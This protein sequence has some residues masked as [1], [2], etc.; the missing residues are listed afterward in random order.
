M[1]KTTIGALLL[2]LGAWTGPSAAFEPP[3]PPAF[4]TI[5]ANVATLVRERA[6][7]IQAQA[8]PDPQALADLAIA[9]E[10]NNLWA[11]AAQ[12][13]EL[14][15]ALGQD[16]LWRF[17][18]ALCLRESGNLEQSLRVLQSLAKADPRQPWVQERL[19][20]ALFERGDLDGAATAYTQMIA[21]GV[22]NPFGHTGLGQVRLTQGDH[23]AA[24]ASLERAVAIAPT[25]RQARYMLGL[26]YRAQGKREQAAQ[27]LRRGVDG[28]RSYYNDPLSERV[29]EATVNAPARR[30][31]AN[32]LLATRRPGQAAEVLENILAAGEADINDLNNLAVAY[33]QLGRLPDAKR[34][35][36]GVAEEAPEHF[37]T[38]LNLVSLAM[39]ERD[40]PRALRHARRAVEVAPRIARTHQT[41]ARVQA[42]TGDWQGAAASLARAEQLDSRDPQ[43]AAMHGDVLVRLGKDAQAAI[44]Y[45]HALALFPDLLPVQLSLAKLHLR[46]GDQEAARTMYLRAATLAPNN[47]GVKALAEALAAPPT[48]NP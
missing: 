17:H 1:N 39:R 27:A 38:Q 23:A 6:A 9:Y 2:A 14:A 37:G 10:A 24:V 30:N 12:T 34:I 21:T 40:V 43:L 35:L 18:Y 5:D 13:W 45:T 15:L 20:E 48:T 7:V 26:A 42:Q 33:L 41:L 25:Y 46:A 16:A 32:T 8:T 31:L 4:E 47:P 29:D 19:G 3:L 22:V 44:R 28:V 36:T 11:L